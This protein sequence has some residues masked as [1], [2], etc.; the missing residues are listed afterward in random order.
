MKIGIFYKFNIKSTLHKL[1]RIVIEK[2]EHLPLNCVIFI[3]KTTDRMISQ[4]TIGKI[5]MTLTA[6]QEVT[7]RDYALL[8]DAE[9]ALL[10]TYSGPGLDNQNRAAL[11]R[12]ELA[13]RSA[14]VRDGREERTLA[15][16][17]RALTI[18]E[19]ANRIASEARN[20]T[21]AQAKWAMWAAIIAIVALI[22]SVLTAMK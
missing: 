20:S 4:K 13:R 11:A 22:V 15:I 12:Y 2:E 8:Q 16:S 19:D 10:S 6:D 14:A 1:K 3:F 5:T 9:L 7:L 17:E 21:A 18:S